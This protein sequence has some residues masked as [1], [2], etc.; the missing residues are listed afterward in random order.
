MEDKALR[1]G[2]LQHNPCCGYVPI[3]AYDTEDRCLVSE[4]GCTRLIRSLLRN[5]Y[6]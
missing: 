1:W 4:Y 3:V 6:I 5:G 2:C